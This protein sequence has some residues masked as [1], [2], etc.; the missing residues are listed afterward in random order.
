ME[1][2]GGENM[3]FFLQFIPNNFTEQTEQTKHVYIF[4]SVLYI[5]I[6]LYSCMLIFLGH[7]FFW[8]VHLLLQCHMRLALK[9]AFVNHWVDGELKPLFCGLLYFRQVWW[10]KLFKLF[11][12]FIILNSFDSLKPFWTS[13]V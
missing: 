8:N 3:Q 9:R 10:T 5:I 12:L 13:F 4:I 6:L 2:Q 7:D 11:D 1:V